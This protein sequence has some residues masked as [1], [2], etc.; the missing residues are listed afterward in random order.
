MTISIPYEF[1][2]EDDFNFSGKYDEFDDR[3]II[4]V[5]NIT[6]ISDLEETIYHEDLHA[7]IAYAAWP[8][9]VTQEQDHKIIKELSFE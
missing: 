1:I 6:S 3:I 8:E 2:Y 4:N 9:E 5:A 7:L